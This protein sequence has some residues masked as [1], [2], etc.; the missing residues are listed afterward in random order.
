MKQ[1]LERKDKHDKPS[2]FVSEESNEIKT[3]NEDEPIKSSKIN[4]RIDEK[5]SENSGSLKILTD[6]PK[7]NVTGNQAKLKE[8]GI[9]I[10]QQ[11]PVPKPPRLGTSNTARLDP[12]A[13]INFEIKPIDRKASNNKPD[14]DIKPD[15]KDILSSNVGIS[16]NESK[17][18]LKLKA[19]SQENA[20]QLKTRSMKNANENENTKQVE[21]RTA[22][23]LPKLQAT[24][25]RKAPKPP[26]V[27]T[28]ANQKTKKET[29][30]EGFLS[31]FYCPTLPSPPLI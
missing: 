2:S 29:K 28:S 16:D 3:K 24:D 4:A 27:A 5:K 6:T 26:D 18:E 9:R 12:Q 11:S 14:K 19:S 7:V 25:K 17:S 20:N 21:K 15:I 10:V 13:Y 8:Q 23:T 30:G 31:A 1:S 22:S